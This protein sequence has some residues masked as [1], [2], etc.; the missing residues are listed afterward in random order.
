MQTEEGDGKGSTQAPL[1][2]LNKPDWWGFCVWWAS[3]CVIFPHIHAAGPSHPLSRMAV[4]RAPLS[5]SRWCVLA[6][7]HAPAMPRTGLDRTGQKPLQGACKELNYSCNCKPVPWS[8][9]IYYNRC[10]CP[11]LLLCAVLKLPSHPEV[12]HLKPWGYLHGCCGSGAGCTGE[13]QRPPP[14]A[15]HPFPPPAV[16]VPPVAD[17][18][19]QPSL[20]GS[21]L[22]P[23]PIRAILLP[24]LLVALFYF[25]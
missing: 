4:P 17:G 3:T 10:S 14:R 25:S 1:L 20:R 23:M 2:L 13:T 7:N 21:L 15:G 8:C 6:L 12:G 24:G 18:T 9:F 19:I 22:H 16:S 5:S 11:L